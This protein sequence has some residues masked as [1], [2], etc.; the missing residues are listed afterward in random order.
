MYQLLS[1]HFRFKAE[2]HKPQR[3]QNFGH[4]VSF[5]HFSKKMQLSEMETV[6]GKNIIF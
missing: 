5:G 2:E 4:F 6:F 3:N 1:L